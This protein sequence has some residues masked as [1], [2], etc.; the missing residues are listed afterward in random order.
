MSFG[1]LVSPIITRQGPRASFFLLTDKIHEESFKT[2]LTS[3]VCEWQT[4]N[5]NEQPKGKDALDMQD[6]MKNGHV[7]QKLSLQL[8]AKLKQ[9]NYLRKLLSKCSG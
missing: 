8:L 2:S 3:S 4:V 6:E 9:G 7:L 1:W 5:D